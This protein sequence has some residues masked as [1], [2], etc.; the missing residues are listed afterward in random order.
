MEKIKIRVSSIKPGSGKAAA[1]AG[2]KGRYVGWTGNNKIILA[3]KYD[4]GTEDQISF[5]RSNLDIDDLTYDKLL[6]FKKTDTRVSKRKSKKKSPKKSPSPRSSPSPNMSPGM[7]DRAETLAEKLD[8]RIIS[9]LCKGK[10]TS[11]KKS[12]A[13]KKSPVKRKSPKKKKSPKEC[14]PGKIRGPSGRCVNIEK[15]PRTSKKVTKKV[16]PEGYRKNDLDN[17]LSDDDSDDDEDSPSSYYSPQRIPTPPRISPIQR[18]DDEDE[19]VS[20]YDMADYTDAKN[21]DDELLVDDNDL[22]PI[23]IKKTKKKKSP[24]RIKVTFKTGPKFTKKSSGPKTGPRF[25]KTDYDYDTDDDS[26]ED[27]MHLTAEDLEELDEE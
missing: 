4:D 12:P 25:S 6:G 23:V 2:S 14:P 7:R 9:F 11:K 21:D 10:R 15:K 13:K 5:Y 26:F 1:V 24:E 16:I 19:L 20:V 18:H 3:F 22:S 8:P 27:P 17:I